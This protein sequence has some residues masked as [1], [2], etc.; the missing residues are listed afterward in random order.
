MATAA[1][2][3]ARKSRSHTARAEAAAQKSQSQRPLRSV[4]DAPE[5]LDS[6]LAEAVASQ[7]QQPKPAPKPEPKPTAQVDLGAR[8]V[9][10]WFPKATLADGTVVECGHSKY[11]HESEAAAKR[12]IS[13][14]VAGKGQKVA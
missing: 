11:G 3:T 6:V 2:A 7:K 10:Y 12:C 13:A 14:L 8:Q 9:T 4:P 5:T 1:A